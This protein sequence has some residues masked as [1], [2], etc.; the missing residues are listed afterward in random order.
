VAHRLQRL[1]QDHAV[2]GSRVEAREPALEVALDH[3]HAVLHAGEYV[4]VGDLDAVAARASRLLE[5]LQQQPVA[6]AQVEHRAIATYPGG[7]RLEV[8]ALGELMLLVA[9]HSFAWMPSKYA[10]TSAW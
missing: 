2:E 6:A 8:G 4:G 5:V 10:R 7:D 1:R 9:V 3:V